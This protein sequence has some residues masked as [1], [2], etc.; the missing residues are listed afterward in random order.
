MKFSLEKAADPK[1]SAFHVQYKS[2]DK[3]EAIDKYTVRIT[4]KENVASIMPMLTNF[5]GG[6]IVSKK[7]V[8]EKG[9]KFKFDPIGTGPFMFESYT[10]REKAVFVKNPDYFEGKP[11][12]DRVELWLMPEAATREMAFEA[13]KLDIIEGLRER[14]W[15]DNMKKIPQ[16]EIDAF[17]PGDCAYL[18]FNVTKEPFNDIRVRRA[19]NY[20]INRDELLDFLGRELA[21]KMISPIAPSFWGATDKVPIYPFDP[22]KAK[23][24]LTEAGVQLPLQVQIVMTESMDYRKIAEQVQEQLRRIG[25]D[26]KMDIV[27]HST[28]HQRTK[29]DANAFM[30]YYHSFSLPIANINL[31]RYWYSN[32]IIGKP[33][34]DVNLSHYDKVDKEIEMAEKETDVKKQLALWAE[35][36]R[37]IMEDAACVPLV[38]VKSAFAR[39]QYVKLGYELHDSM[40]ICPNIVWNTDIVR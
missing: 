3:V 25:V 20:G 18:F 22:Q 23:Q 12:L 17:G 10:P 28:F 38:M 6:F 16:T 27:G 5:H 2:V 29:N 4:L 35:A 7:A 19:I 36:Q 32:T 8:L 33:A 13:G 26:M 14:A 40:T 15:I 24:L 21:V 1:T 34:Q 9:D 11:K 31:W 39:K 30:N 37:K